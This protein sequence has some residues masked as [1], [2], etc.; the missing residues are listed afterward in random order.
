[1]SVKIYF[2]KT[3]LLPGEISRADEAI[4][5]LSAECRRA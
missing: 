1:M 3:K 2:M 5:V 4:S